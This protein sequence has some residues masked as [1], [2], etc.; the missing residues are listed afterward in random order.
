MSY[1]DFVY[2]SDGVEISAH[3]YPNDGAQVVVY[4]DNGEGHKCVYDMRVIADNLW[5]T[6]YMGLCGAGLEDADAIA[7][8]D[9]HGVEYPTD[10]ED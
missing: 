10:E 7:F 2:E 1:W 3:Y 8:L 4:Q 9:W 5:E 6:L